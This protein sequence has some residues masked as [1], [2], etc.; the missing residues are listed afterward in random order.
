MTREDFVGAAG[1]GEWSWCAIRYCW[2]ALVVV[3]DEC[4][5]ESVMSISEEVR[6]QRI[7]GP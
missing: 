4:L 1:R 5:P 7:R 6:F 3:V 2:R